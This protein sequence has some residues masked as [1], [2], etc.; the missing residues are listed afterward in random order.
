VLSL[1]DEGDLEPSTGLGSTETTFGGGVEMLEGVVATV[2]SAEGR[3]VVL[4]GDDL[5][6]ATCGETAFPDFVALEMAYVEVDVAASDVELSPTAIALTDLDFLE[7]TA[8]DSSV[9]CA[10]R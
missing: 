2:G 4:L 1:N 3:G 6:G 7:P 8:L 10:S 9:L 5:Y